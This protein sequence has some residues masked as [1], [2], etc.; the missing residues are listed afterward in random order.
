L[1]PVADIAQSRVRNASESRIAVLDFQKYS[2]SFSPSASNVTGCV[3]D[4]NLEEIEMTMR[5]V[6]A[7]CFSP[8]NSIL[9]NKWG[10]IRSLYFSDKSL[11]R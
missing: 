1:K 11:H 3:L 2:F 10:P 9:E 7:S 5:P 8:A 6:T 4:F